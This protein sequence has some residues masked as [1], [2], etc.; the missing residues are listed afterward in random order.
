[1]AV[2]G[3][4]LQ[5]AKQTRPEGPSWPVDDEWKKG[6]R[7]DM[8]AMGISQAE[9][10]RRIECSSQAFSTLWRPE[11]QRSA[12][13]G[14]IHRV[15]G[16]PQPARIT[17]TQTSSV[18]GCVPHCGTAVSMRVRKAV[19]AIG[20]RLEGDQEA[21]EVVAIVVE[22]LARRSRPKTTKRVAKPRGR[23]KGR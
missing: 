23:P 14:P 4:V 3:S 13:V 1:M 20:D 2:M 15:L 18:F 17:D 19:Q 22:V 9:M 8:K 6:V 7:R 10:A 16:R 11:T 21:L 12:L 5:M